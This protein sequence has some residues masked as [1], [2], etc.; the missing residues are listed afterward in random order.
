MAPAAT[1]PAPPGGCPLCDAPRAQAQAHGVVQRAAEQ[2]LLLEE[3]HHSHTR[4]QCR[5]Q[6]ITSGSEGHSQ[7]LPAHTSTKAQNRAGCRPWL[8]RVPAD[9]AISGGIC[10]LAHFLASSA[11]RRCRGR[12]KG[13]T[14]TPAS[15]L[16]LKRGCPAN[17][18]VPLP[19]MLPL[20]SK[21]LMN[22]RL[23]RLPVWKSLGS[24]AGVIFT[25]PAGVEDK[26]VE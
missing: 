17:W 7:P 8:L 4:L 25:A 22:S 15:Q 13:H 9:M 21:T 20:S 11:A 10:Q 5:R 26:R 1:P 19:L 18:P 2:A 6:A 23:C 12:N 24:W 3:V 14:P 16:A